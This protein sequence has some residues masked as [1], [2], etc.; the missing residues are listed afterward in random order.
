[1]SETE[2]RRNDCFADE[3]IAADI[4]VIE[5]KNYLIGKI[6]GGKMDVYKYS[7]IV[8]SVIA[9]FV[10]NDWQ[11]KSLDYISES[12]IR[13]CLYVKLTNALPKEK[14]QL[15]VQ[16]NGVQDPFDDQNTILVHCEMAIS[17]NHSRHLDIGIW[18]KNVSVNIDDYKDFP[19]CIGIEIKYSWVKK[20]YA[21]VVNGIKDD[22]EK[23]ADIAMISP[24]KSFRGYVLFFLPR[25]KDVD[26]AKK[27]LRNKL[28]EKIDKRKLGLERKNEIEI[29]PIFAQN[30]DLRPLSLFK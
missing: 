8:E 22:V 26:N 13:S 24:K 21:V 3:K 15:K 28:E 17:G 2:T 27:E 20:P 16:R 11:N 14:M 6:R 1:M 7:G 4:F 30:N 9:N 5:I 29:F 12:D 23:L 10:N 18:S 19:V 25:I